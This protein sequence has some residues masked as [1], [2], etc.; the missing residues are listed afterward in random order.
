MLILLRPPV[1]YVN[2]LSYGVTYMRI[3]NKKAVLAC[4]CIA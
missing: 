1:R 4:V 2:V 3:A